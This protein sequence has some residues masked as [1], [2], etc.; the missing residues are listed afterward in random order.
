MKLTKEALKQLIKEELEAV[1]SESTDGRTL[2]QELKSIG[3]KEGGEWGSRSKSGENG[4]YD[5]NN[6][7]IG[8]VD[9]GTL[10]EF[11]CQDHAREAVKAVEAAGYRKGSVAIPSSMKNPGMQNRY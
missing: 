8:F 7:Y 2:S 6:G 4:T 3:C 10:Y 1:M 11:Y 5:Y 9:N